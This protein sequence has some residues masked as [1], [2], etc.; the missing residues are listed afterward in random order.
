LGLPLSIFEEKIDLCKKGDEITPFDGTVRVTTTEKL[1]T[2][3]LPS[4]VKYHPKNKYDT[5][6][7]DFTEASYYE[8]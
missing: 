1:N 7:P 5:P 4:S 3:S 2:S 8:Y 6:G